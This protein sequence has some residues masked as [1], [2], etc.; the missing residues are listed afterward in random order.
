MLSPMQ[1]HDICAETKNKAIR[2]WMNKID[3]DSSNDVT[4]LAHAFNLIEVSLSH[5]VSGVT[6]KLLFLKFRD[7]HSSF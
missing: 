7:D 1:R 4:K 5:M 2:K 3:V 6:Y